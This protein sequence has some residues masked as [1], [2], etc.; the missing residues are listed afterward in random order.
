MARLSW[1]L[2]PRLQPFVMS[3]EAGWHRPLGDRVL[4]VENR[5]LGKWS[6]G[7]CG[8]VWLTLAAC[9]GGESSQSD[10][11]ARAAYPEALADALCASLAACC[12]A[13]G[14][15]LNSGA[16]LCG[17]RTAPYI[18]QRHPS[19]RARHLRRARGCG[20]CGCLEARDRLWPAAFA[21]IAACGVEAGVR[22]Y[23][24]RGRQLRELPR[25]PRQR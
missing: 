12:E 11:V 21:V 25:V 19:E 8:L 3:K 6:A 17:S 20:L 18:A 15:E 2:P 23:H 22:R 24:G 14:L 13:A 5:I 9:S 16:D 10:D 1:V 4:R 7:V